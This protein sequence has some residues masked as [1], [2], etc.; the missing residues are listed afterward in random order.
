MTVSL[1]YMTCENTDEARRIGRTLVEERL[2]A[3]TN[4]ITGMR[5]CYWWEGSV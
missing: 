5:S 2:V 1:I 4:A 3:C